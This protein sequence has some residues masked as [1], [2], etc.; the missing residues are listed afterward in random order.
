MEYE[1][2]H[3][4]IKVHPDEKMYKSPLQSWFFRTIVV[5]SNEDI[6]RKYTRNI[7]VIRKGT[8]VMLNVDC[9]CRSGGLYKKFN[10]IHG[11]CEDQHYIQKNLTLKKPLKL[12]RQT[13][14]ISFF[15]VSVKNQFVI[16][17][18]TG[19]RFPA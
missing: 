4:A 19:D 7:G 16:E 14:A 2:Q 9:G 10:C 5:L 3:T 8:N 12:Y 13:A 6:S 15:T 18:K 1:T 11:C 17:G